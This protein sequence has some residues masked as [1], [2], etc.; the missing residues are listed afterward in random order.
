MLTFTYEAKDQGGRTV[1]GSLEA[2]DERTA[3]VQV[4]ALGYYPMRLAPQGMAAHAAPRVQ[5][6]A[7][8]NAI[9]AGA[10]PPHWVMRHILYPLW[11]GVGARDLSICYRQFAAMLR[12]GVPIYQ[13]LST[14]GMQ[15]PN[16]ALRRCLAQMGADI[17]AGGTLS[18][19]MGRYPWIFDDFQRAMVTAGE[20][21]GGLDT[22]FGR[23][24][25]AL[26]QQDALRRKIKSETFY[27]KLTGVAS[28]LLPPLFYLFLG[29]TAAYLQHA[30]VPL[31]YIIGVSL[32]LFI[33]NRLGAQVRS[34]YDA[35]AACLPG[36]GGTVRVVAMARFCRTLASLYAA[37]I[38]LPQAVQSAADSCG[39]AY[40]GARIKSAI[41]AIMSGQGL[42]ESLSATRILP[43]MVVS[44]LGVGE[45]T[46]SL[47][48]TMDKVAEHYEQDAAARVHQTSVLVGNGALLLAG[49]YVGSIVLHFYAGTYGSTL[50]DLLK[51]E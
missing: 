13:S 25:D 31:I 45:Q 22:M 34:A 14:L 15:T 38:P 29:D 11:S 8:A 33:I 49:L 19:A 1:T 47:D 12:A 16:G 41:P 6:A 48:Q 9:L 32:G 42:T 5:S 43:P 35:L 4:R 18:A 21:S 40:L 37:G 39:N 51:N 46:G 17:R 7:P 24:A 10:A 44:M 50:N 28:F 20:Q 36:V 23:I 3:V 27:P 26:E 2:P 30:V